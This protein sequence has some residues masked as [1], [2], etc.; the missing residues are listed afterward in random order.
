MV[1]YFYIVRKL[2]TKKE[3]VRPRHNLLEL[4]TFFCGG[5]ENLLNLGGGGRF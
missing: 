2:L 3:E 4:H 1:N 5:S